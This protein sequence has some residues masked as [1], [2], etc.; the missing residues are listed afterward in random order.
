MIKYVKGS[1]SILNCQ[2]E[3]FQI[4]RPETEKELF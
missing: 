3:L 1:E 4:F 2:N